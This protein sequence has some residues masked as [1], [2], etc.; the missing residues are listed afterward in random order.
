MASHEMGMIAFIHFTTNII[1]NKSE[2]MEMNVTKQIY[3]NDY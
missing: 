3:A 1:A 2:D